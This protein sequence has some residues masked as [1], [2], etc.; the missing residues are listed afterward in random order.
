M[1]NL[2]RLKRHFPRFV[3]PGGQIDRH[4]TPK[5]F[6][7]GYH[8]V[9]V[10]DVVRMS[11]RFPHDGLRAIVPPAVSAVTDTGL[12]RFWREAKQFQP[13]GHWVEALYHLCTIDESAQ[14]R[15]HL[16]DAILE[17]EDAGIG[18][19]PALLGAD[20]EAVGVKQQIPC[21]SPRNV[22]LRIANLSTNSRRE[23]L[24]VNPTPEAVVLEW[25]LAPPPGI[26]WAT[27]DGQ[28]VGLGELVQ[29]PPRGWLLGRLD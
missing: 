7:M 18:L 24:V 20:P 14:C 26:A 6:D 5:H 2:Y 29:V 11:R 22:R 23:F 21:P 9:N 19:S 13:L 27:P 10:M 25:D 8:A 16:A 1:P 3:M 28:P 15:A 17:V 12:L 4:L